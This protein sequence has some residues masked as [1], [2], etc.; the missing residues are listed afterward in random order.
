MEKKA[1]ITISFIKAKMARKLK[2]KHKFQSV[3]Y[4]LNGQKMKKSHKFLNLIYAVFSCQNRVQPKSTDLR[5][6]TSG[7]NQKQ[8]MK[9]MPE[10]EKKGMCY[11]LF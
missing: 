6:K 7:N 3:Q 5:I 2:K 9:Y 1:Y 11:N 4:S 8:K 10:N